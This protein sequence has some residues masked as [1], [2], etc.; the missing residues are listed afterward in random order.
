MQTAPR[1]Q[2]IAAVLVTFIAGFVFLNGS[3]FSSVSSLHIDFSINLT[4]AHAL[5]DGDNPYGTTTLAERAERLGS[6]CRMGYRR[7]AARA[8]R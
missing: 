2:V 1:N 7:P 3:L 6:P 8:P 4:A 5:R